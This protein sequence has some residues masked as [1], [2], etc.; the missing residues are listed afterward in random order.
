MA[1]LNQCPLCGSISSTAEVVNFI[2]D[3][4]K[5][6][7]YKCS[8]CKQMLYSYKD[9]AEQQMNEFIESF[10]RFRNQ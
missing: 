9:E 2:M 3:G 1:T 7:G 6:T 10:K 5:Y 4:N 8:K